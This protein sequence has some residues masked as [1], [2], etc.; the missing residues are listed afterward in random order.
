MNKISVVVIV[1]IILISIFSG[2]T[3]NKNEVTTATGEKV[4]VKDG[5]AGPS[6]CKEGTQITSTGAQGQTSFVIKGITTY[7]GNEVC[8]A[9]YTYNEG[10]MTQYFNEKGDY[11]IMVYKD[12]SGKIIQEVNANNPK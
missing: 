2:C 4:T 5:G 1:S 7:K 6:W 12:K 3:G 8:E 10:S 11:I 9:E